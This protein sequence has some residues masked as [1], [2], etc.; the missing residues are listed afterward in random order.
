MEVKSRPIFVEIYAGL[1]KKRKA[2]NAE[3]AE[4]SQRSQRSGLT[5][6]ENTSHRNI[7]PPCR[8]LLRGFC[9]AWSR[10]R[11]ARS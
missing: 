2:F 8:Y 4:V 5:Q 3:G 11:R 9:T 10:E 7:K 1:W 6:M